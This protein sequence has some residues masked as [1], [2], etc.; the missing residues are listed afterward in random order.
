MIIA[1]TWVGCDHCRAALGCCYALL[2]M[3]LVCPCFPSPCYSMPSRRAAKPRYSPALLPGAVLLQHVPKLNLNCETQCFSSAVLYSSFPSPSISPACIARAWLSDA[4]P[5]QI[6]AFRG[7][8]A[9]SLSSAMPLR[10]MVLHINAFAVRIVTGLSIPTPLHV[11]ATHYRR[12][13]TRFLAM[14]YR[15]QHLAR[16]SPSVLPHCLARIFTPLPALR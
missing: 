13:A 9:A 10:Y 5:R 2:V 6:E 8:G 3:A 16:I 11:Q 7:Y 4:M 14:L 1:A 15:L 12:G